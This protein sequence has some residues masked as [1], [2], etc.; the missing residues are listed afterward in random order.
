MEKKDQR[1]KRFHLRAE[2]NLAQRNVVLDRETI[3]KGTSS[4][5][6]PWQVLLQCYQLL[7]MT[8]H[9]DI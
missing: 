7:D 6:L 1:A 3:K 5:A 8:K 9:K 4:E 2:E